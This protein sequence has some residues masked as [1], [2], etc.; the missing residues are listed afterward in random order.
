MFTIRSMSLSTFAQGCPTPL[1]ADSD[2]IWVGGAPAGVD[3]TLP[4]SRTHFLDIAA[5][6]T[7][8]INASPELL[9]VTFEVP[10]SV[11]VLWATQPEANRTLVVDAVLRAVDNTMQALE[12]EWVFARRG[13]RG[14]AQID[15]VEPAAG[16]VFMHFFDRQGKPGIH[17]HVD[18]VNAVLGADHRVSGMD[19]GTFR[20]AEELAH[21]RYVSSLISALRDVLSVAAEVSYGED[22]RSLFEVAGVDPELIW[23]L[24]RVPQTPVIQPSEAASEQAQHGRLRNL[25]GRQPS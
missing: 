2:G 19:V 16:S 8:P 24:P 25:F 22:R 20:S 4:V 18:V 14:I 15:V 12:S 13:E 23:D 5:Q 1:A 11:S 10:Q 17:V 9:E 3:P 21:E 6:M 7:R